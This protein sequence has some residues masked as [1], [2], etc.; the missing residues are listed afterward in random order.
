MKILHTADVHLKKDDVK[1]LEIFEWMLNKAA[2]MKVD[3]F[4]I[5]GDLFE[6]DTD[7]TQLRKTVRKMFESVQYNFLII[8]GNH[9]AHAFGP[10]YDY[11]A[12]VLQ[13]TEEPF[14]LFEK[15]GVRICGVP[16][17]ERKFSDCIRNVPKEVDFLVA[18]GTLY[19]QSFIFT[20]LEDIETQYMPIYPAHLDGIARYVA[21]GHLHSRSIELKYGSTRVVYPGSPSAL[22][23]KCADVRNFYVVEVDG[24]QM[25]V[26]KHRVEVA[27]YWVERDFFVFPDVENEIL[28]DVESFLAG[29]D[30]STAMP[31]III[32]GY[33]EARE[34]EFKS[35]IES[36]VTK[37]CEGFQDFRIAIEVQS[38][39]VIMKNNMVKRFVSKTQELDDRLRTKVFE[40][41]FPIFDKLLR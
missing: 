29:V 19:D 1:R 37:F 41:T 6:S 33:T 25:N 7:A 16:Y 38:W 3:C 8:P 2:E 26:S 12:N 17:Q 36:V 23:T 5:A 20:M 40:I 31:N 35:R 21:L 27:P 30:E 11:G 24:S 28:N 18:H 34:K 13:L 4:A 10:G 22:D 39:D 15:G 9:D 14:H 32:Q